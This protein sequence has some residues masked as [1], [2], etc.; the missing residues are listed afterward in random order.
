VDQLQLVLK[1]RGLLNIRRTGVFK[2]P[3]LPLI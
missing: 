1:T 2:S 3:Q